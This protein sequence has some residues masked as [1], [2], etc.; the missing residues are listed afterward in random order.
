MVFGMTQ[1]PSPPRAP[2]RPKKLKL[3][4]DVRVDDYFW[5]RDVK[6]PAVMKYLKEENA[7]FEAG[8]KPLASLRAKLFRE[9]KARIQE[10]DV[11]PP[12]RRGEYY[13]YTRFKRGK[14]YAISCRKRG[15]R[16]KEE[17]VLDG[18]RLA[19]GKKYFHTSGSRVSPDGRTL[20]YSADYDG[21]ERYG[22]FIKDLVTGRVSPERIQNCSGSFAWAADNRTF[23]YVVLDENIRPYRV[24][25]HRVGENPKKD[26]LVFEEKDPKH[27]VDVSKSLSGDY[28]FIDTAGKVTSET[29]VLEASRSKGDFRC[30]EP[31]KEGVEYTIEHRHGDFWVL[32]NY[33][34]E[35]FQVMKAPVAAPGRKHWRTVFK[36][37]PRRFIEGVSAYEGYLVLSER[38]NGLPHLRVHD[39][40]SGKQHRIAVPDPAYSLHEGANLEFKTE[41]LRIG[42]SSP[43]M[44]DSAID[45]HLKSRRRKVL[46]VKKVKGHRPADYRCER[47]WVKGH[48]GAR[49]PLTLVMKRSLKLDGKAPGYLYGYGS[50]GASM[51][52][53]FP[54]RSDMFRLIDRGFVYA[55]AHIRGGSEMG[56]DWYEQGKFLRKKNTFLDFISCAEF[57][58][59]RKYVARDRL[60]ACGGSA[61]GML[62]GACMN[63]RPDLFRAIAAHV[64]FVDVLNTMLD[65]DLPLTQTEYKEWGNP[66]EKRFYR[67]MKSYSPYDNVEAKAYPALFVTCGLNDPRVTYWEP[68]KWVA[69]LRDLKTD[70]HRILFKTNMGFGHF[71]A[72]GRFEYL[73]EQA[74]EFAFIL[75]ELGVA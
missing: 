3:H 12:V 41:W 48:D 24:Y 53:G 74:E 30:I 36:H 32:T 11:T 61:G 75:R 28:I 58:H 20:I 46:K 17:I 66:E 63:L 4:G 39:F 10:D 1:I 25:R 33:R 49:I 5:L 38:E 8:M 31:R 18:N 35:N 6:D 72:S 7:Y 26:E 40:A 13:Y 44:P 21:S 42:Y 27:F 15:L 47:V 19:R 52:D 23:Y 70:R 29:W 73:H 59:R 62:M 14:Q 43:I 67:Y 56:R 71:G 64:P 54:G 37:S 16:C 22:L 45:Y 57:L 34:A 65:K 55:L 50:Y 69:K 60:S 9:M 2:K 51:P 68:A